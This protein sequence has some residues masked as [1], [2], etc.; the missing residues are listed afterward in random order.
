M[1]ST[2]NAQDRERSRLIAQIKQRFPSAQQRSQLVPGRKWN[3]ATNAQLRQVLGVQ[4]DAAANKPN[5]GTSSKNFQHKKLAERVGKLAGG[6][7]ERLG[8]REEVLKKIKAAVTRT[9]AQAKK[10]GR[11]VSQ[12]ELRAAAF[13]ALRGI[14]KDNK[15]KVKNSGAAK[16]EKAP[17]S[18]TKSARK[19]EK[20]EPIR[21]SRSKVKPE[22]QAKPVD[23]A[24]TAP[25]IQPVSLAELKAHTKP[26]EPSSK[27]STDKPASPPAIKTEVPASKPASSPEPKS[28]ASEPLKAK[29]FNPHAI[30]DLGLDQFKEYIQDRD[31]IE[32]QNNP[33]AVWNKTY[34]QWSHGDQS[35]QKTLSN[36]RIEL[37]QAIHSGFA[38]PDHI[39]RDSG[40]KLTRKEQQKLEENKSE[41]T[42]KQ[43][44]IEQI[45]KAIAHPLISDE[46]AKGY[47]PKMSEDE[48][49]SYTKDSFMGDI[50][51]YHGNSH[52]VTNSV[53]SEGVKTERNNNGIFGQGFYLAVA[54][55]EA[56]GY[57]LSFGRENEDSALLSTKVKVKNPYIC[58]S[59]DITNIGTH[60]PG[61]QSSG[62]DSVKI[63]EFLR[64][65]GHDSIYMKDHGYFVAFDGKQ[66]ATYDLEELGSERKSQIKERM[67][68]NKGTWDEADDRAAATTGGKLLKQVKHTESR[69]YEASEGEE[70]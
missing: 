5:K 46:E 52:A 57:A 7:E 36:Y 56:E 58:N 59:E 69:K 33:D 66:V 50:S 11:E 49:K 34:G 3:H 60:F 61:N 64:A 65:K 54:K 28:E 26:I 51:F 63:T 18:K 24:K 40:L 31:K 14:A 70:W 25:T 42:K 23:K 35:R 22:E 1:P 15:V 43:K 41:L 4:S 10:E 17:P 9:R 45:D 20:A 13:N 67:L 38:P 55:D 53:T 47:K 39:L 44:N 48:A 8:G 29:P 12:Q 30:P 32:A 27:T 2:S 62:T 16:S 21:K 6:V 37:S 68:S 19:T